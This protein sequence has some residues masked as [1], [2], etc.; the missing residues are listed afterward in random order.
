MQALIDA[1]KDK[2]FECHSRASEKK[3]EINSLLNLKDT[4]TKRKE[5]ILAESQ[6][7][8]LPVST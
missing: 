3:S 1:N 8:M 2:I 4:L 6:V 7:E 5:Q